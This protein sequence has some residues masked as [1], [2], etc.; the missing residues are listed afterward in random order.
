[1]QSES[2]LGVGPHVAIEGMLGGGGIV[3]GILGPFIPLTL[4]VVGLGG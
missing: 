3:G 4:W 2:L 1:M